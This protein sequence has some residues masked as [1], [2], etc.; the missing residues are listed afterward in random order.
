MRVLIKH[1]EIVE[2]CKR[3]GA[4]ITKDYADKEPLVVCVLKGSL[5][6]HA[7]LIKHIELPLEIDFIQASSYNGGTET[8]GVVTIKKD[9]DCNIEGR[10]VILVE[11][12]VDSGYTLSLLTK[13][14]SKRNPKSLR[15]V[16]MLDKPSNRR[17]E[18]EADY[19][20]KTID[21]LF[22][23]GFG[24]DLDEKYRNLQDIFVYNED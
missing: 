17:V 6:F 9:L 13:E 4:E 20:G 15:V 7:E 10:D 21:N 12:I 22:V 18:F 19:V 2:M 23:I 3:I 5:P 8:S 16:S 1:D 14:L 11:D 24:L